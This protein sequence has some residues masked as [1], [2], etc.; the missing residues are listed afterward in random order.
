MIHHTPREESVAFS[1]SGAEPQP[2]RVREACKHS[3][4]ELAG[5]RRCTAEA[6]Q[7]G[8]TKSCFKENLPEQSSGRA[9]VCKRSR[10]AP[11]PLFSECI[12]E[13]RYQAAS[14]IS[15]LPRLCLP[16]LSWR[17]CLSNLL[18]QSG[19]T[20]PQGHQQ[21]PAS[22]NSSHTPRS[23]LLPPIPIWEAAAAA[24]ISRT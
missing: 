21:A 11:I 17:G 22:A 15:P 23:I 18:S 9:L 2:G 12:K 7:E 10:D 19:L 5:Q 3:M 8:D 20:V 4:A 24:N 13:K 16:L 14:C 6:E 1:V